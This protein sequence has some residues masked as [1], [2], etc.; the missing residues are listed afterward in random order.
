METRKWE[1]ENR[2]SAWYKYPTV[3]LVAPTPNRT[4]HTELKSP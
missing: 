2:L 3:S 1:R 4:I